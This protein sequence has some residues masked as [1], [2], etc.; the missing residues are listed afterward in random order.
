MHS[1]N[2]SHIAT[3]NAATAT[4]A[5]YLAPRSRSYTHQMRKTTIE[6]DD[7]LIA[8]ASAILGTKGIKA[9]VHGALDDLVRRQMR[10]RLADRVK[11]QD[12]LDLADPEVMA[13]AWR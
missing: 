6:I 4:T 13:R 10:L 12:G 11:R 1:S 3:I 5:G 2:C 8:Q 7:D 9:T